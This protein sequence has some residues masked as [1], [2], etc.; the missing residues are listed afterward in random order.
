MSAGYYQKK[1]ERIQKRLLKVSKSLKR[2]KNNNIVVN[3]FKI[4]LEKNKIKG[5]SMTVYATKISLN[6]KDKG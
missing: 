2:K 1:K 4:F 5:I 6:M 3:N